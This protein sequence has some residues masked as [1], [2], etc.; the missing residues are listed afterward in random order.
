MWVELKVSYINKKVRYPNSNIVLYN[1]NEHVNQKT[2][3]QSD[4]DM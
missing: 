2:C 1:I 3:H 4:T